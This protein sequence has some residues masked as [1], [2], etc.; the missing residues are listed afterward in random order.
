MCIVYIFCSLCVEP[1]EMLA[2]FSSRLGRLLRLR[3]SQ[4]SVRPPNCPA[5]PTWFEARSRGCSIPL[6]PGFQPSW[7]RGCYCDWI[8]VNKLLFF[9]R[10]DQHSRHDSKPGAEGAVSTLAPG[11][12][13]TR[14][15]RACVAALRSWWTLFCTSPSSPLQRGVANAIN[16]RTNR[17]AARTLDAGSAS[18]LGELSF[19][20]LVEAQSEAFRDGTLIAWGAEGAVSPW[21]L[22]SNHLGCV[23]V[24]AIGS[25]WTSYSSSAALTSTPDMIRS[26]EPRVQCPPWHLA[27]NQLGCRVRVLR[28]LDPGEHCSVRPP[29]PPSSGGSPMR[30]TRGRTDWPLG[31]WMQGLPRLWG[32]YLFLALWR[33]SRRHSGMEPWLPGVPRVQCPPWRLASKHPGCRVCCGVWACFFTPAA[34]R[35]VVDMIRSQEPSVQCPTCHLGIWLPTILDVHPLLSR[36]PLPV[37]HAALPRLSSISPS[38]TSRIQSLK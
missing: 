22:A 6:A 23:G 18:A 26:Q 2:N 24:T 3:I 9:C 25:G 4:I 30:S 27:S 14:M 31:P 15:S 8:R 32:S 35:S 28:R 1:G 17:L 16:T 20:G 38:T 33:R 11:F 36:Q 34:L 5:L 13:P 29:P 10:S 21:R 7:M 12:Q 37:K 19:P